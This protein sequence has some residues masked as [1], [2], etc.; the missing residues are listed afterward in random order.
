MASYDEFLSYG[1]LNLGSNTN[2]VDLVSRTAISQVHNIAFTGSSENG[3]SYRASLN[4][5]DV[6]GD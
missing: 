6:E 5:R 4:Y 2:W 3:L 1:G